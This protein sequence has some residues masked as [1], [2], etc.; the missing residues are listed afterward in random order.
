MKRLIIVALSVSLFSCTKNNGSSQGSTDSTAGRT[1]TV[2]IGTISGGLGVYVAGF[3]MFYNA[4]SDGLPSSA[5][6]PRVAKIW[7]DGVAVNMTDGRFDAVANSVWADGKDVYAVGFERNADSV[8]VAT[9]WKNGT[10][11]RLG[12]GK[13]SSVANSV[14]VYGSDVYVAGTTVTNN[15]SSATLWKNGTASSLENGGVANSVFVYQNIVYV[16]GSDPTGAARLWQDGTGS[17]LVNGGLGDANSVY[18]LAGTV[19][20]A[21]T[22]ENNGVLP[23]YWKN[24][25][26]TLLNYSS[27]SAKSIFAIGN[28]VLI[29]GYIITDAALWVNGSTS[30][31]ND[32]G[33]TASATTNYNFAVTSV[34]GAG[35]QIHVAGYRT[36]HPT[37]DYTT[38]HD[39]SAPILFTNGTSTTLDNGD[40]DATLKLFSKSG[41]RAN[42]VFVVTPA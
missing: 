33:S 42:A 30:A 26:W 6:A 37:S 41:G 29:A 39:F 12:D 21:G 31:L 11:T 19:Y 16:C 23:G 25:K 13:N 22:F 27:G 28:T 38:A 5:G 36:A 32:P 8:Q 3:E 15:V 4:G 7:K 14:Y 9:L 40:T 1:S 10:S 24:G 20:V 2:T 17:A 34:S 18:V 35:N